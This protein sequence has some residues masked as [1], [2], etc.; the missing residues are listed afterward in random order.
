[1]VYG[2][3]VFVVTG[4]F[5]KHDVSQEDEE[6]EKSQKDKRTNMDGPFF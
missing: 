2:I 5:E 3:G 1:M 6:G 4:I